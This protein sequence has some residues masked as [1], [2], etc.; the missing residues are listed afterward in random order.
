M[1]HELNLVIK[2][3][4]VVTGAGVTRSDLGVRGDEIVEPA[5]DL[6]PQRAARTIDATGRFV[7]PGVLDVHAHP[8]YLDD[9]GGISVMAAH[10]Q[11]FELYPR[12]GTVQV[13]SDADLVIWDPTQTRALTPVTGQD[14][15]PWAR[16]ERAA[17]ATRRTRRARRSSIVISIHLEVC[18]DTTCHQSHPWNA[19]G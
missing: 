9:R 13:G 19:A 2:G 3:G 15:P 1:S 16:S 4:L 14:K 12:K 10:G 5:P 8:V 18:R 6:E 11:V 17:H 7:L